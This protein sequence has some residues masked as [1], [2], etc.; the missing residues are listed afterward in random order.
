[1][2]HR[3]AKHSVCQYLENYPQGKGQIE[4]RKWEAIR[5][6]GWGQHSVWNAFGYAGK[7]FCEGKDNACKDDWDPHQE[8]HWVRHWS[9]SASQNCHD[10]WRLSWNH[11]VL[12]HLMEEKPYPSKHDFYNPHPPV[13]S[14]E[15]TTPH[16]PPF[17]PFQTPTKSSFLEEQG[18]PKKNPTWLGEVHVAKSRWHIG[19]C[20]K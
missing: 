14:Q 2:T 20:Q 15:M 16:P 9:L 4:S 19:R 8:H 12:N 11:S 6:T 7:N 1:M 3:L 18:F 17:T 13:F 5:D 10:N